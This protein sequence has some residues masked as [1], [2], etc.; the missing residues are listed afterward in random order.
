MKDKNEQK[1]KGQ[2]S[3]EDKKKKVVDTNYTSPTEKAKPKAGST[4]HNEGTNFSYEEQ[5]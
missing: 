1:P 2:S 4:L 3:S 5:R